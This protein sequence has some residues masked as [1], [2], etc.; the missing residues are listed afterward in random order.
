MVP[1]GN[2][3]ILILGTI[4]LTLSYKAGPPAGHT[5]NTF[6]SFPN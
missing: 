6:H 3:P 5:I 4:P 1:E 2:N